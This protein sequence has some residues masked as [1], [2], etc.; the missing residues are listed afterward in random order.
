M[1]CSTLS[2][3]VCPPLVLNRPSDD[4][5]VAPA[6]MPRFVGAETAADVATEQGRIATD[7]RDRLVRLQAWVEGVLGYDH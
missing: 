3:P 6:L 7:T 1:G 5:M 2:T 4:L